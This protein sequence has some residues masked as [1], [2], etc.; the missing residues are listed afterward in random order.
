V[1]IRTALPGEG[2][3][4]KR[5]FRLAS[6]SNE[7][8]RALFAEHPELLDWAETPLAEQRTRVALLDGRIVGFHSLLVTNG[9]AELEDLFVDPDHMGRG[10]GRALTDD[11]A[12]QAR[13]RGFHALEVDANPHAKE[14]YAKAGFQDLGVTPVAYGTGFRMRRLL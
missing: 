3:E 9:I 7:G 5:I 4:L 13:E 2:S 10:V 12:A 11:A 8:D 6:M 14:F 1:E